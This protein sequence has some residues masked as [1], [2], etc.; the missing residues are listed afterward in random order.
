MDVGAGISYNTDKES[1]VRFLLLAQ[2]SLAGIFFIQGGLGPHLT[3]WTY[4][5][6]YHGVYEDSSED[7]N[8]AGVNLGLMAA[9]GADFPVTKNIS[10]PL[11]FRIDLL[12]RYGIMVPVTLNSGITFRF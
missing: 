4:H 2:Y 6:E 3:F 12:F 9:C 8:G 7:E 1:G 10:I 5:Y 11:Y